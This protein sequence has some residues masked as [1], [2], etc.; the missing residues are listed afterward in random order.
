MIEERI[1]ATKQ[2]VKALFADRADGH[3]VEHTLRVYTNAMRIAQ[4]EGPC[5]LE[6]VA[7]QLFF[8][9]LMMINC[10]NRE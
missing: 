10:F 3:D 7:C 8:T 1:H 4:A 6:I 2:Y 5:D 9:M